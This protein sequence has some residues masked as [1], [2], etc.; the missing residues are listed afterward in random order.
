MFRT[1]HA[2]MMKN[3]PISDFVWHCELDTMKGLDLGSTYLIESLQS[4]LLNP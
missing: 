1:C 3:K 2:L 4:V